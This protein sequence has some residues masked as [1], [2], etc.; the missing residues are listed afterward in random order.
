MN[1]IYIYIGYHL[2][3]TTDHMYNKQ[4]IYIYMDNHG[5]NKVGTIG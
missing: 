1:F 5:I 4:Y 2:Y 3:Q